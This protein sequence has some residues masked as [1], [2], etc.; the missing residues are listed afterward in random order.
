MKHYPSPFD[1]WHN[2]PPAP[3]NVQYKP[4]AKE[5]SAE[6]VAELEAEGWYDNTTLAERQANNLFKQRYDEKMKERAELLS[7]GTDEN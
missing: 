6:V 5:V 7:R 1:Y 2:N 3:F 4:Y